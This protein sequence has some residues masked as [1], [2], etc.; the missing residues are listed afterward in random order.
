MANRSDAAGLLDFL[1]RRYLPCNGPA[2]AASEARMRILDH[3]RAVA[4]VIPARVQS[5]PLAIHFRYRRE[6][7]AHQH[8]R[9]SLPR[10]G[11]SR[12][13]RPTLLTTVTAIRFRIGRRS[14]SA[15]CSMNIG[16]DPGTYVRTGQW[17]VRRLEGL[18]FPRVSLA[19]FA[20]RNWAASRDRRKSLTLTA[21]RQLRR[22]FA[23]VRRG[24]LNRHRSWGCRSEERHG[25]PADI[26]GARLG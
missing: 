26:L 15:R 24:M 2:I 3:V 4:P 9:G 8:R 17:W 7:A 1:T 5:V 20:A 10:P 16:S 6:A 23:G 25:L 21:R 12:W 11:T 22:R 19:D 14:T 13:P 18:Y